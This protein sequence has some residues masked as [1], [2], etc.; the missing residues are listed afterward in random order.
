VKEDGE[1]AAKKVPKQ[2]LGFLEGF[3]KALSPV[4]GFLKN[5]VGKVVT[6]GFYK[7]LGNP[8]N[9]EKIQSLLKFFKVIFTWTTGLIGMGLD[10]ILTG[11]GNIFGSKDPGQSNLSKAF[12]GIFGV[13]KIL[14]GVASL[15]LASRVL[16]P[17]KLIGD[18]KMMQTIGTALTA[19]EAQGGPG[20][21]LKRPR[22]RKFKNIGDRVRN[23][24]R[25]MQVRG[26]RTL[27]N[28][29]SFASKTTR[30]LRPT[31][32]KRMVNVGAE[33]FKRFGSKTASNFKNQVD[34][35]GKNVGNM[36][37]RAR[38][39][40]SMVKSKVGE[41]FNFAKDMTQKQLKRL[42]NWQDDFV[43]NMGK[44]WQK[45]KEFG[46]GVAKKIG[47][48]AELAKDPKKLVEMVKGNLK[49][50]INQLLYSFILLNKL[51]DFTLQIAL[52]HFY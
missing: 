35:L 23:M 8:A 21:K 38:N 24:R 29:K 45:M 10:G 12:E 48:I 15:W 11:V 41:G 50:K 26:G 40:G 3:A 17:W 33:K 2:R 16:F 13:F 1:A 27:Q 7:W 46:K 37:S 49:G 43:K 28:V 18:V 42:S 20:T 25:R 5:I 14:G 32:I 22:L 39:I 36:W 47:D 9:V 51:I 34:D 31:N 52:Y 30:R 44:N 6:V 19:A 4:F